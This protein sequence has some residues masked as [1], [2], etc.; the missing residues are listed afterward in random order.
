MYPILSIYL[1]GNSEPV[2]Y[3]IESVDLEIAEDLYEPKQPGNQAIALVA[4]FAAIEQRDPKS[5]KEVRAWA[6]AHKVQTVVGKT[7]DPT[8][9]DPSGE[10]LSE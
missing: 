1:D 6:R 5:V 7:A 8:Q 3:Q 9:P 2:T 10:P 4:A